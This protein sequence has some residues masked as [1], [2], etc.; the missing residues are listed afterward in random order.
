TFVPSHLLNGINWNETYLTCY[1]CDHSI[2]SSPIQTFTVGS[3]FSLDQLCLI[4]AQVTGLEAVTSSPS[5]GNS[6]RPRRISRLCNC[7][8]I[9][10]YPHK[11]SKYNALMYKYDSP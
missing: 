5:I 7:M 4:I 9:V 11:N 1:V 2:H 8:F 10:A 3:R 6:T